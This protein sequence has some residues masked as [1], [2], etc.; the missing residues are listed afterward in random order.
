M[1]AEKFVKIAAVSAALIMSL[2]L[3]GCKKTAPKADEE[4]EKV[5]RASSPKVFCCRRRHRQFSTN[6]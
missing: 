2:S 1:K 4:D 3:T 6:P 5:L